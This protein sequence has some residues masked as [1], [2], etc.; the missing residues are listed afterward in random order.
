MRKLGKYIDLKLIGR[1]ASAEVYKAYHPELGVHRALKVFA[2]SDQDREERIKEAVSQAGLDHPGIIKV[3]DCGREQG[4][5]YLVMEYAPDGT[6]RQ[7]LEQGAFSPEWALDL[8][9]QV[10]D[11]LS[12]AH[13]WGIQHLDLKPENLLFFGADKVKIADFGLARSF[14]EQNPITVAAG[15]PNYMAPEQLGGY[16]QS[17][18]D[19]WSLGCLLYEMLTG[20]ICFAG[21][22]LRDIQAA[23]KRGPGDLAYRLREAG[24]EPRPGLADLLQRLLNP[25]PLRRFISAQEAVEAID[26]VSGNAAP[27]IPPDP[28]IPTQIV[29]NFCIECGEQIPL[30]EEYCPLCSPQTQPRPDD[31]IVEIPKPYIPSKPKPSLVRPGAGL[32]RVAAPFMGLLLAASAAYGW[33]AYEK[34]GSLW[35]LPVPEFIKAA[36]E[37]PQAATPYDSDARILF[38]ALTRGADGQGGVK[39]QAEPGPAPLAAA[40][41]A[42]SPAPIATPAG[43]DSPLALPVPPPP[44]DIV[45]EKKEPPSAVPKPQSKTT[46]PVSTAS[47]M[48]AALKPA[49]DT[50][51][52][53]PAKARASGAQAG[54]KPITAGR[55]V[56]AQTPPG[57][58]PKEASGSANSAPAKPK[59]VRRVYKPK[60]VKPRPKAA[61]RYAAERSTQ[62]AEV[63]KPVRT[64]PRSRT[65][66]AAKPSPPKPAT[67]SQRAAASVR[68]DI[69]KNPSRLGAQRNLALTYMQKGDYQKALRQARSILK[70]NPGDMEAQNTIALIRVLAARDARQ[71]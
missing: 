20:R 36:K 33:W 21:D 7:R 70:R 9:R 26:R 11:A 58:S 37:D 61:A 2:A 53:A 68:G 56:K 55:T 14:D 18:S 19:L 47:P 46:D 43:K 41:L 30:G 59:P 32:F 13:A 3:L 69:Q 6:L 71:P 44:A 66:L 24:V 49:P 4:A 52:A 38:P 23:V 27:E 54:G 51:S 57:S 40:P 34:Q 1:G 29:A 60:T 35:P 45:P 50:E 64:K 65:R 15:T 22:S 12:G 63:K 5:F 28:G 39:P 42:E 31:P 48:A 10:A 17:A 25:L 8:A 67:R 62:R 16:P